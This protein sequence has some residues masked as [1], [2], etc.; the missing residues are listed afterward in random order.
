LIHVSN[1]YLDLETVV[2][3]LATEMNMMMVVVDSDNG[4]SLGEDW[5]Y[6]CEDNQNPRFAG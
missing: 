5:I 3:R 6:D 1:K 4:E 2:R